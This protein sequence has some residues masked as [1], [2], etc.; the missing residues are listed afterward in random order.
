M[1]EWILKEIA[2]AFKAEPHGDATRLV[3]GV[4]FDSRKL[5]QGQM[6][7][8]VKTTTND[9]HD[10]VVNAAEKGMSGAI[11]SDEAFNANRDIWTELPLISVPD[12]V[13]ALGAWASWH[14]QQNDI[15]V[16]AI[17]GSNGKT[18]VKELIAAV[19]GQKFET[20]KTAANFNNHLGV[21]MTL[22]EIGAKHDMAVVEIGM[23]HPGE[24]G[25]LAKIA[26]PT[27]GVITN[28][29]QAHM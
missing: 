14:R 7:V 9:G 13:I 6:F 27:I 19:L 4:N 1:P 12:P 21:P 24:I 18:T 25:Q 23:N 26:R 28:A 17:T 3:T 15:P 29:G 2:A 20:L 10:Y 22:L 11:V 8:A 16:V 5:T